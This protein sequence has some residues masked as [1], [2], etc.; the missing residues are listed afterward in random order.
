MTTPQGIAAALRGI[1]EP[2]NPTPEL[3]AAVDAAVQTSLASID[4]L[5][6]QAAAHLDPGSPNLS[7]IQGAVERARSS[8]QESGEAA[9]AALD[10]LWTDVADE[11]EQE[12]IERTAY[13]LGTEDQ[14]ARDDNLKDAR[15]GLN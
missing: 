1:A 14:E 15:G 3:I 7:D 4:S 13:G 8:V 6:E 9:K 12:I 5:R 10:N 11:V 2:P